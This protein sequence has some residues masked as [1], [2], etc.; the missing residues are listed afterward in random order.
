MS[1]QS[2]DIRAGHRGNRT[3]TGVT[4]LDAETHNGP[5]SE[6]QILEAATF[7]TLTDAQGTGD[8]MTGFAIAAGITLFG[9]FTN[10]TLTS[11]K[12]RLYNSAS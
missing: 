1:Q 10:V 6:I 5:W 4:A 7:A 11:G 2:V 9:R 3:E 12:I 8:A